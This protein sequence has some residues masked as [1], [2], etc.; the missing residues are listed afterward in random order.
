[1]LNNS[2]VHMCEA[3]RQIFR[4]GGADHSFVM[5]RM[6]IVT[7]HHDH[8]RPNEGP[9][10]GF[11]ADSSTPEECAGE[12]Y[13]SSNVVSVP[14]LSFSFLRPVQEESI[15]FA[16]SSN[17]D[18][19]VSY[20]GASYNIGSSQMISR[21]L[22]SFSYNVDTDDS[23]D[24]LSYSEARECDR[25]EDVLLSMSSSSPSEENSGERLE[26]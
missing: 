20:G 8:F 21:S 3:I 10:N 17:N 23:K 1:M 9:D 25:G 2:D 5:A 24:L 26:I 14:S 7:Y 19:I 4:N 16:D 15:P 11:S 18:N 6:H 12:A 13:Q 22:G